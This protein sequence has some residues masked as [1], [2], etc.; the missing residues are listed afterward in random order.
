MTTA[1]MDDDWRPWGRDAHSA[2]RWAYNLIDRTPFPANLIA[3]MR[4]SSRPPS[5][6]T[7]LEVRGQAAI[8]RQ[9]LEKD[10]LS[11]HPLEASYLIAYYLPKPVVERKPGT[12]R[13]V[14]YTDRYAGA[15][16]PHIHSLAWHLMGQA[17][18]GQH[19]IRAYQEMVVQHFMGYRHIERLRI[20]MK[21]ERNNVIAANERVTTFLKDLRNRAITLMQGKLEQEGLL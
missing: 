1:A 8:L 11:V 5:E 21:M 7:P 4:S 6:L 3:Q 20:L 14:Q 9:I 15:R 13:E 17:G 12:E 2:L 18:N 16:Q 19:R 10:L